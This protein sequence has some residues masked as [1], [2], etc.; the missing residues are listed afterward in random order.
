MRA[1]V[2]HGQDADS[3]APVEMPVRIGSVG[4][5][6]DFAS[7]RG[8]KV[9]AIHA[10]SG[11]VYTPTDGGRFRRDD[12]SAPATPEA[13]ADSALIVFAVLIP[14]IGLVAGAI[15]LAKRDPSGTRALLA[16]LGG[17]VLWAFVAA[18]VE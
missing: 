12:E 10:E 8:V 3:G 17:M 14:P 2:V 1:F 16:G 5:A 15:R 18:A 6:A 13:L 11:H 7:A 4:E 9:T